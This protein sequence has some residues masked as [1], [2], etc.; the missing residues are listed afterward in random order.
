M[1]SSLGRSIARFLFALGVLLFAFAPI[2][3]QAL[4]CTSW[5][6]I[7]TLDQTENFLGGFWVMGSG[8]ICVNVEV[9]GE[10]T[11]A[12]QVVYNN[13]CFNSNGDSYINWKTPACGSYHVSA[14]VTESS[15]GMTCQK[16]FT[17]FRP[18]PGGDNSCV[19]DACG[20]CNG[21][22]TSCTENPGGPSC[23]VDQCGVCDGD[24]TSCS[25]TESDINNYLLGM[26]AST[27]GIY[28]NLKITL[29]RAQKLGCITKAAATKIN[30]WAEGL[31]LNNWLVVNGIPRKDVSCDGPSVQC[32]QI[33][34][35]ESL[36]TVRFD[37]STLLK[38]IKNI[39]KGCDPNDTKF[40]QTIKKATILHQLNL[41]TISAM[42]EVVSACH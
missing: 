35:A 4:S 31:Q 17:L 15:T 13:T 20:V 33:D 16:E 8:Q 29:N 39:A 18:C 9:V 21:S 32:V 22:G 10:G 28:K 23:I 27:L 11:S 26:D 34:T 2:N 36:A 30:H 40:K 37:S 1:S 19:L 6:G 38:Q 41:A 12:P 3:S 25:C 24:G 42:P 5:N 7:V 14:T